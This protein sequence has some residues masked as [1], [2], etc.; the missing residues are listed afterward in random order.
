MVRGGPPVKHSHGTGATKGQIDMADNKWAFLR[1]WTA[2]K[3]YNAAQSGVLD[4]A[5]NRSFGAVFALDDN[6]SADNTIF[7]NG[8]FTTS[9][10]AIR[11]EGAD[12][13]LRVGSGV[14]EA[15]ATG[16]GIANAAAVTEA[17]LVDLAETDA[18]SPANAMYTQADQTTIADLVNEIKTHWN[19]GDPNSLLDLVNELR[20]LWNVSDDLFNAF[21]AQLLNG[22]IS[23]QAGA[24]SPRPMKLIHV[25]CTVDDGTAMSVFVNGRLTFLDAVGSTVVNALAYH[26]GV[27]TVPG[28]PAIES[29]IAGAWYHSALLPE[30]DIQNIFLATA[31]AKQIRGPSD[32]SAS[33]NLDYIWDVK[34]GNPDARANW[35]SRGAQTPINMVRNGTWAP[36]GVAGDCLAL[37]LD[38]QTT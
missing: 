25:A 8:I 16:T 35:A 7:G 33:G 2:A 29:L 15:F 31:A 12:T 14:T 5:G 37:D 19:T 36:T 18:V 23:T 21:K 28:D 3:F 10:D 11:M 32:L 13:T 6:V 17:A 20:T 38:F 4:G 24:L 1:N 22:I 30:A 34:T 26:I 27:S 9:G